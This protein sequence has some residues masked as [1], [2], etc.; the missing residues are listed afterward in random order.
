MTV[1]MLE[2]LGARLRPAGWPPGPEAEKE[3]GFP[4]VT[5][6]RQAIGANPG[7]IK[8]PPGCSDRLGYAPWR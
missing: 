1:E 4:L 5:S 7:A 8:S 6:W 2:Q 3:E